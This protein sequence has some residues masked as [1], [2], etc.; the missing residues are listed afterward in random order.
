MI[1]QNV[2]NQFGKVSQ[3]SL[4]AD[5]C[6]GQ[7]ILE[8]VYFTAPYKIMQPFPMEGGGIQVMP[9][10]ASAGIMAGDVQKF[11]YA[12]G[13]GANLEILSQAFEKIH[14]MDGGSAR[15]EIKIRVSRGGQL[16]Y[17]P[18]PVIPFAGSAFDSDM[19]IRL[20][21]ETSKL[22][23]LDI[24]SCG[25]AASGERFAY[26]RFASKVQIYREEK[27]IYRDNTR[28]EPDKMPME[29]IGMYEGYS[30]M[31]NIFLTGC[32]REAEVVFEVGRPCGGGSAF[33]AGKTGE[34]QEKIWGILEAEPECEGGVT[35][36]ASGDLA[37]RVFGNRAQ[38]L[39][40]VAERIKGLV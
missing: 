14:K 40:E 22:F 20:A 9:L 39:Q 26:R 32:Y 37:V 38:K 27:L 23:L 24:L 5:V 10:C 4:R 25:R 7:T 16:S 18:Q 8:D 31:A 34:L 12:V 30:H 15:R 1:H 6:D 17:Y 28:Y 11:D 19:E 2:E 13:P 21:D 33:D 3:L 29:G 35:R 36:L